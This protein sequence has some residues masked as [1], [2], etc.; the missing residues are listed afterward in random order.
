L[1]FEVDVIFKRVTKM[2]GVLVVSAFA[3]VDLR[4]VSLWDIV[5]SLYVVTKFGDLVRPDE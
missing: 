4:I 2:L 3:R 5:S 1:H